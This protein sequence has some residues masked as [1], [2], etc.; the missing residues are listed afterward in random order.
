MLNRGLVRR[1]IE[2]E[3][4]HGVYRNNFPIYF[5]RWI[6]ERNDQNELIRI[7]FITIPVGIIA[8]S[9]CCEK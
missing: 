8:L 1:I 9:K 7:P 4:A 5:E 3:R 2:Q 6:V